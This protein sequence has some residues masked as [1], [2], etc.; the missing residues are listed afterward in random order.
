MK[1]T[2]GTCSLKLQK[3]IRISELAIKYWIVF[4]AGMPNATF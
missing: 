1:L 4:T 2:E 3:H